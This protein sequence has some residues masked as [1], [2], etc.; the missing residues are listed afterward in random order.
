M[1]KSATFVT[2]STLRH[3]LVMT[4]TGAVGLVS[5]FVVDALNL[6]YISW[7]GKPA[8]TAAVGYASTVGLFFIS[9]SIGLSIATS[10]LVSRAIGADDRERSGVIA[11]AALVLAASLAA[12]CG[13]LAAP[14]LSDLFSLLGASGETH[15][16][17]LRFMYIQLPSIPLLALGMALS[18]L[19]RALGDPKRAMWLTL[20]PAFLLAIIDPILI[21]W[22]KWELDGA[23]IGLIT[24]RVLMISI[25]FSSVMIFHK[26][27]SR[28]TVKTCRSL[29]RPFFA[30]AIPA[31]LTQLASPV[32][33]A[34][35]TFSM[36]P[37]GDEA[38]GGWAVIGRLMPMAF[39][40]IY[41]LSGSIGPIIG[42]NY[43]AKRMDRVRAT[44]IDGLKVTLG[45]CICASIVL[46][47][48]AS[49]IANGF[50]VVGLGRELVIFF[51]VFAASSFIF[52]GMMFVANAAFN[53]LGFAMYSTWLNWGRATLGVL[54][55][56]WLG[57]HWYG[58]K[59]VIAGYSLGAVLF[60][61]ISLWFCSKV[62]SEIREK[63]DGSLKD[64]QQHS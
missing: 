56:V 6:L 23:A 45:Y 8:L 15:R 14:F 28:P 55:F 43:G 48:F 19:L 63:S 50:G 11:S 42:Q 18:G 1:S 12:G 2:G 16:Y 38:V 47:I 33:N 41:A 44:L 52:Q 24:A 46:A 30:I 20:F 51:C 26:L 7:L 13:L 35:V 49:G 3:V 5:I 39:G 61:A 22:M 17:A 21:F 59:G 4:G 10:A 57:G 27:L 29:L 40:V 36:A 31:A 62:L 54:P 25:G 37:Y 9:I 60:G 64:V 34:M 53:N 58:A 32:A